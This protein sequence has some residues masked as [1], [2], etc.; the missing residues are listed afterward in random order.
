V[1]QKAVV[2]KQNPLM[3]SAPLL[4]VHFIHYGPQKTPGSFFFGLCGFFI[5][6]HTHSNSPEE[7]LRGKDG[8][9]QEQIKPTGKSTSSAKKVSNALKSLDLKL[10]AGT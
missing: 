9:K 10:L 6:I 5:P 4:G 2:V 1:E 8:K 3:S 7:Y